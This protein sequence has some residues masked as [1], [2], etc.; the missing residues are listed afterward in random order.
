MIYAFQSAFIGLT[1]SV[2]AMAHSPFF[3][4]NDLTAENPFS[5]RNIE[6]SIAVYS[7]LEST[8]DVDVFTFE[9]TKPTQV[10]VSSLVPACSRYE[11]FLP[12]F[13]VVGPALPAPSENLPFEIPE[14]YGA[15]VVENFELGEE[16]E[17]FYEFFADKTYFD[18][19]DFLEELYVPGTYYVYYWDPYLMGGDYVAVLGDK[20]LW[21]VR[22]ILRAFWYIPKLRRDKEL[23]GGECDDTVD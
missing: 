16:R 20:E 17:T 12:A 14:D 9:L 5:V 7:W 23:H 2:V 8:D 22:D 18:G 11:N 13:A 10:F 21:C 6:K 4:K 19:P 1:L 15:I 3:E